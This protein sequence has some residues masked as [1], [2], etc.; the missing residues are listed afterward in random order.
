MRKRPPNGDGLYDCLWKQVCECKL[1]ERYSECFDYLTKETQ[2]WLTDRINECELIT[3]EYGGF[4]AIAEGF[5]PR[6]R[7]ETKGCYEAV[8]K[9][10]MERIKCIEPNISF[11]IAFPDNCMRLTVALN[12]LKSSGFS[13]K[14]MKKIIFAKITLILV[15]WH[16]AAIY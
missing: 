11:C 14:S 6:D 9:Q 13:T 7:V 12:P 5:C 10:F 4:T 1:P 8:N 15:I 16:G 3:V 2:D